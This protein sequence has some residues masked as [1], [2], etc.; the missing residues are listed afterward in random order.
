MKEVAD[1]VGV[2]VNTVSRALS[3]KSDINTKT[4]EHIKNTAK[5]LGYDYKANAQT[6]KAADSRIIGLVVADNTNPFYAQV[7]KGVQETR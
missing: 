2:S 6:G 7:A 4:K 3:N 1:K 5:E